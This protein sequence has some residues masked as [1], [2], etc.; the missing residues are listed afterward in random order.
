VAV[1]VDY[2]V[3]NLVSAFDCGQYHSARI[4]DIRERAG[5]KNNAGD[6]NSTHQI[7]KEFLVHFQG[8]HRRYDAWRGIAQ[9]K[10]LPE[11]G[12][13]AAG[14]TNDDDIFEV[15]QIIGKRRHRGVTQYRVRC[16]WASRSR[17][18]LCT[19]V[20]LAAWLGS[21]GGSA[22]LPACLPA[23]LWLTRVVPLN[24]QK[25]PA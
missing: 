15:A 9:L 13:G 6:N 12:D 5:R 25:R 8:W 10:P 19:C 17:G 4:I 23:C 1:A 2:S 18:C 20:A 24:W 14:I 11:A 3:G 21:T 7:T 22:C 16:E